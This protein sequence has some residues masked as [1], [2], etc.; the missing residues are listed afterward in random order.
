MSLSQKVVFF[1]A[2]YEHPGKASDLLRIKATAT[3]ADRSFTC[4]NDLLSVIFIQLTTPSRMYAK[5]VS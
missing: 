3:G 1:F 4:G 2:G 5:L